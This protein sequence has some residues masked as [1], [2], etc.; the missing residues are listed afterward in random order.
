MLQ[1]MSVSYITHEI[2]IF[3]KLA[4]VPE[5]DSLTR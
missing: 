4:N 1:I 2:A 5:I 3:V